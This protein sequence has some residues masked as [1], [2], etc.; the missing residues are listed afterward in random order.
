MKDTYHLTPFEYGQIKAHLEHDERPAEIRRLV[1]RPDGEPFSERCILNAVAKLRADPTFR[2][3]RQEGSG[4]PRKTSK[5]LDNK[6]IHRVLK[7]RGEVKVTVPWLRKELPELQGLSDHLI[8]ERLW[9]AGL[10]YLRRRRKSLVPDKYIPER[11]EYAE[12]V[13]AQRADSLRKWAYV[14]GTVWF[15]TK[16]EAEQQQRQRLALGPYIY[17]MADCSDALMSDCVGPSSY[18]KGQGTPVKVW[19][20]LA[21]GVLHVYVLP[22]GQAMNRWWFAW[23]VEHRLVHWAGDCKHIV[24]DYERCL[25]CEEPL[26]AMAKVGLK[27]V[28]EFPRCSQDLNAI[29]MLACFNDGCLV[30][31]LCFCR[32]H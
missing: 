15:L 18:A 12:W 28:E 13:L 20:L 23:L 16:D 1:L 31:L 25:R 22:A 21:E 17:R 30:H 26:E 9:E 4:A 24:Q 3:E 11:L 5:R 8:R 6:I 7:Y 2:G 29:E 10:V 32:S 19:G 27:L 14:D